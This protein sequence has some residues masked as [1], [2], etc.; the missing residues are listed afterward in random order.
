MCVFYLYKSGR[1]VDKCKLQLCGKRKNALFNDNSEERNNKN[2][3]KSLDDM[4][5]ILI[6]SLRYK[7]KILGNSGNKTYENVNG[8]M[9]TSRFSSM[10]LNFVLRKIRGNHLIN[11]SD[12]ILIFASSQKHLDRFAV[13][14]M[15]GLIE[16]GLGVNKNKI[17]K[18]PQSA[19]IYGM[20]FQ[21]KLLK[22][23]I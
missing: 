11:F 7:F 22:E 12:D 4:K 18:T 3:L 16:Q 15:E 23:N 5:N 21:Q 1:I 6:T 2:Q 14:V 20:N 13:V 8:L 17:N 9:P 10:L 19:K